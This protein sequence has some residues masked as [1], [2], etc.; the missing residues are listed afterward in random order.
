MN[1]SNQS[2]WSRTTCEDVNL[3]DS[4]I[5]LQILEALIKSKAIY[6]QLQKIDIKRY[7]KDGLLKEI[8]DISLKLKLNEN[9]IMYILY[10]YVYT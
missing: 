10:N 7:K 2:H 9:G 1:Q 6:N 5:P 8:W 3:I 4:P